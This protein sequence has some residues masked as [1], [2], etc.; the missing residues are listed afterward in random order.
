MVDV[1]LLTLV[2]V[3]V[4][5]L[6]LVVQSTTVMQLTSVPTR[7]SALDLMFAIVLEGTKVLIAAVY[8]T[9]HI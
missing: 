6:D 7:V 3:K 2:N 9:V 8:S 4:A 5:G 1:L